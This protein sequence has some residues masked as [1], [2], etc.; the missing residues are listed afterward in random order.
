[1]EA[2]VN[3]S[4]KENIDDDFGYQEEFSDA[5]D[6]GAGIDNKGPYV[7]AQSGI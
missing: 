1:M 4:Q 2:N 3:K 7:S 6:L 5:D